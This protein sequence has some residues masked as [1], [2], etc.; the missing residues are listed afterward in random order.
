MKKFIILKLL[1]LS[2]FLLIS[3]INTQISYSFEQNNWNNNLSLCTTNTWYEFNFNQEKLE[4]NWAWV[5]MIT[6]KSKN[7]LKLKKINLKWNGQALDA[8]TISASLYNKKERNDVVIPIEEN[9][10]CDGKWDEKNQQLVFYLDEKLIAVKKYYLM[11]SF[12]ENI[13]NKLRQ[14]EFV[15]SDNNSL[16]IKNIH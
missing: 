13:K 9:L 6:L 3:K 15:L 4:Q 16:Q 10:V 5:G 7:A 12:P 14:G 8:K 1:I 2:S 11:L